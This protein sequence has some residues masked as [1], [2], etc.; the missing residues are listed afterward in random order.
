MSTDAIPGG[1]RVQFTFPE[2]FEDG[3]DLII[4]LRAFAAGPRGGR[5]EQI[6]I[7]MEY[8]N[9]ILPKLAERGGTQNG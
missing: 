7:P 5:A 4:E 8:W 2:A 1:E 9:G 6:N 3:G